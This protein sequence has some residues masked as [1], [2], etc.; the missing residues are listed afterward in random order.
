MF[1]GK[2]VC[3]H[4]GFAAEYNGPT[5]PMAEDVTVSLENGPDGALRCWLAADFPSLPP[6]PLSEMTGRLAHT[7]LAMACVLGQ[8]C[9]Y[10]HNV[11][12]LFCID[13]VKERDQDVLP[14]FPD[15]A[16]LAIE[17]I[18][19]TTVNS[20]R[21][22]FVNL[23]YSCVIVLGLVECLLWNSY[24]CQSCRCVR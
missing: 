16:V 14:N 4:M 5:H 1:A 10:S 8:Q 19:H 2:S 17:L 23:W 22:V 12:A 18:A 6:L 13:P 20:V 11:C 21:N 24:C 7:C 9:L 15:E 3:F